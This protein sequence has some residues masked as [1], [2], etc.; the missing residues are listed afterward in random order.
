[1]GR[2]GERGGRGRESGAKGMAA[3]SA[4]RMAASGAE[5]MAASGAEREAASGAEREGGKERV[6]WRRHGDRGN[7][8]PQSEDVDHAR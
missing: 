4:E 2:R 5:R 1:M 8:E 7:F 3:S 6:E